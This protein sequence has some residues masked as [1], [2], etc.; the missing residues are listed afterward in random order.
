MS[1]L[2]SAST[3]LSATMGTGNIA[4]VAGAVALGGA[5][6]VFWMWVSAI[7]SMAV[8][9]AE[10]S[11]A[12]R[13]RERDSTGKLKGGLPY[14]IKSALNPKLHFLSFIFAFLGMTASFGLVA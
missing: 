6:A 8:K 3:A 1:P 13:Y 11:L 7:L 12:L 4:G 5:G 14:I 10:I 2:Q 9:Y